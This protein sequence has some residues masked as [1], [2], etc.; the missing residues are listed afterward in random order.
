MFVV[1]GRWWMLLLAVGEGMVVCRWCMLA[2]WDSSI[3]DIF[4][5]LKVERS[6]EA[7][8]EMLGEWYG[9]EL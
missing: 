6:G 3:G 9:G 4:S 8:V 1:F 7:Q 5:A 2:F